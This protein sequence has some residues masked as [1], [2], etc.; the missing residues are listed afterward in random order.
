MEVFIKSERFLLKEA[1]S[2]T[3]C[4]GMNCW[5]EW[6]PIEVA[7][8]H[9]NSKW[10]QGKKIPP[11]NPSI[12]FFLQIDRWLV[13][14]I[15]ERK[16]TSREIERK[17]KGVFSTCTFLFQFSKRSDRLTQALKQTP[18]LYGYMEPLT[19]WTVHKQ[20]IY[21]IIPFQFF[22]PPRREGW[23]KAR[24]GSGKKDWGEK[25]NKSVIKNVG[26]TGGG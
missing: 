26:V 18:L 20:T 13:M 3:A 9:L 16:P 8:K 22:C 5:T 21:P 24:R 11:K 23:R 6:W 1:L 17:K 4:H 15:Y 12:I 10:I 2:L 19:P 7:S 25:E 14:S